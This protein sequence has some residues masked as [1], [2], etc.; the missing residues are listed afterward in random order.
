MNVIMELYLKS[1][2]DLFYSHIKSIL[3]L[4]T[5]EFICIILLAVWGAVL[6]LKKFE[7]I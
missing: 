3:I 1:F 5:I 7:L 2:E 6:V 4:F